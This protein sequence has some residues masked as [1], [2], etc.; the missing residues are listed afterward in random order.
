APARS[1]AEEVTRVDEPPME[2]DA[3]RADWNKPGFRLHLQFGWATVLRSG[4]RIGYG[5]LGAG[6][7]GQVGP[8]NEP[9]PVVT[10]GYP[11]PEGTGSPFA[12]RPGA[13]IDE[14]LELTA[15]L[16]YQIFSPAREV[17]GVNIGGARFALTA[18]ASWYFTPGIYAG[19][20]A[21]YG[22]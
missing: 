11:T 10:I 2:Q 21:G 5:T 18:D 6:R 4:N 15:G 1:G 8:G 17:D 16:R 13:R 22:G 20:G 9:P 14:H 12:L 3:D 7:G 19:L